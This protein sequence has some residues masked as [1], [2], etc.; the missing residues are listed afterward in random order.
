MRVRAGP[1]RGLLLLGGGHPLG[2]LGPRRHRK[3]VTSAGRTPSTNIKRHASVPTGERKCQAREAM[4][5]PIPRPLCMIPAAF[6]RVLSGHVSATRDVPV[7]HSEPSARP[8]TNRKIAKD[9]HDHDSA[10][11]PVQTA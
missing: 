9:S 10:V 11:R 4:K 3:T 7:P 6:D 2:G 5:N 8:V 1:A